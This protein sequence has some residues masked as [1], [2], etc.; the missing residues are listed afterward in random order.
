MTWIDQL[1]AD[2]DLINGVKDEDI[3]EY[4]LSLNL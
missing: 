2:D 4:F 1:F 3:N